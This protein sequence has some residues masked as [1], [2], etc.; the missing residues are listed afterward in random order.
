VFTSSG[1]Q[2]RSSGVV[3]SSAFSV[4]DTYAC[5]GVRTHITRCQS[6]GARRVPSNRSSSSLPVKSEKTGDTTLATTARRH[7][8][9]TP[10]LFLPRNK[11]RARFCFF[12]FLGPPHPAAAAAERVR[13]FPPSAEPTTRLYNPNGFPPKP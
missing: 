2:H 9:R 8:S 7:R 12:L 5:T 13:A 11:E 6:R 3:F 4:S 10:L 1:T